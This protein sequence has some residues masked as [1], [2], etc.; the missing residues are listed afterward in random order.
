MFFGFLQYLYIHFCLWS[1]LSPTNH[2]SP[3]LTSGRVVIDPSKSYYCWTLQA[4]IKNWKT[5]WIDNFNLATGSDFSH[6][7][8]TNL[9]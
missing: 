5:K 2:F 7:V 9:F 1:V 8:I 3:N 6:E 4:K